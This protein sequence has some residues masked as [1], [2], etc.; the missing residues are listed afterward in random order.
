M[1]LR[2]VR[3]ALAAAGLGLSGLAP[4]AADPMLTDTLAAAARDPETVGR[5]AFTV[6]F[7]GSEAIAFQAAFDPRLP[8]GERWSIV[9]VDLNDAPA[10]VKRAYEAM[11]DD[12]D[13]DLDLVLDAETA[14]IEGDIARL[15]ETGEAVVFGYLPSARHI[16]DD[17]EAAE[18]A[19]RLR[20]EATVERAGPRIAS[21]RMYA[22]E[23][24]KPVP[25][26]R[27]DE[28]EITYAFTT[29]EA[30]GPTFVAGSVTRVA[31]RAM[32]RGFAQT[33]TVTYRDFE[34]VIAAE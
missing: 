3:A 10:G 27:I 20:A 7:Q 2:D 4:A 8:E 22:T 21:V 25:V 26:A 16:G 30:G 29:P 34:K 9:D 28:M 23:S 33:V 31:G 24:F 5:W 18:M 19:E 14:M 1:N 32:F 15:D 12:P 6:D 17:E 11:S 13:A